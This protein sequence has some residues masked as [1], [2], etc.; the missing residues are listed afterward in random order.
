MIKKTEI[1]PL[2]RDLNTVYNNTA[3]AKITQLGINCRQGLDDKRVQSGL[4]EPGY[5]LHYVYYL[6]EPDQ[7]ANKSQIHSVRQC[8]SPAA[9]MALIY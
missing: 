2:Y 8:Q 4:D 3:C 6:S 7:T 5:T 1:H 9:T